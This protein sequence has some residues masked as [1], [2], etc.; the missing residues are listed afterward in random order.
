VELQGELATITRAL[1]AAREKPR[2]DE[3]R[4][5]AS[6]AD[7]R[8]RYEASQR[9]LHDAQIDLARA[10]GVALADVLALPTASDAFPQPP[11]TLQADPAAY[12]SLIQ[13]AITR[14]YDRQAALKTQE[15]GKALLEGARIDTRRLVNLN[16][17][18][19]GTS[20][21]E[22]TPGYNSWVFRSGSVGLDYEVP[23]GNNA[24]RG[25]LEQ[26]RSAL[27]QTQIDTANLERTI[28]L[29]ITRD[30]EAL[31][32]AADRLK[33]AD[34]AVRNYDQTIQAEQARFKAGDASLVDTILTEQQATSARLSLVTAR[35]EYGT[36]LAVLRYEAGLLVRDGSVSADNLVAVPAALVRR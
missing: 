35:Q 18:G 16:A 32:V 6:T 17:K 9:Q 27:S 20:Q 23:F 3:A 36:L 1:I 29:N 5:M 24:A 22:S 28:A 34:E 33:S 19:W 13:E 31:K 10:M 7:A 4:V 8:S 25:L 21:H 30:A 12:A 2:S 26:R 14:R 11:D 15:S